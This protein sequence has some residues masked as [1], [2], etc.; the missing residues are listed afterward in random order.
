MKIIKDLNLVH[1]TQN[2]K[3]IAMLLN[4]K[5]RNTLY[6]SKA[7]IALVVFWLNLKLKFILPMIWV[8]II[9]LLMEA[10]VILSYLAI[11]YIIVVI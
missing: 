2:L 5:W 10:I 9:E 8:T 6:Y 11:R 1:I 3:P 4:L 7:S